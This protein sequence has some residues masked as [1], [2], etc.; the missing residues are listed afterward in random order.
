MTLTRNTCRLVLNYFNRS[1]SSSL[2]IPDKHNLQNSGQKFTF[3]RLSGTTST[4][5]WK[6]GKERSPPQLFCEK[7]N[8]VQIPLEKDNYFKV[9]DMEEKFDI[10]QQQLK[11][12]FRKMQTLLHPDKF[13]NK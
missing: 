8:I 7:C 10:D 3:K 9:F 1:L 11:S 13:S 2:K 5:C 6:C 12:K 4:V